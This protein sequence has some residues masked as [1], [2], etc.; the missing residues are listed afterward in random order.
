MLE[1]P[2][3]L[4]V[5]DLALSQPWRVLDSLARELLHAVSIA[6]KKKKKI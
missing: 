1:F 2:N 3:V 4:V 5:K 6:K